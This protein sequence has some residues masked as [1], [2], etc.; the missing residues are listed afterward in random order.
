M[1][2]RL[3]QPVV[4]AVSYQGSGGGGVRQYDM[5]NDQ[6]RLGPA[7]NKMMKKKGYHMRGE[8]Q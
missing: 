5:C 8:S 4:V 6:H 2:G 1:G 3:V 7:V